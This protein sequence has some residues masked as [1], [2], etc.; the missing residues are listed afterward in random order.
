MKAIAGIL[1]L[2]VI[3]HAQHG[4]TS[5]S[6]FEIPVKTTAVRPTPMRKPS[7]PAMTKLALP[8]KE[9]VVGVINDGNVVAFPLA[10]LEKSNEAKQDGVTLKFDPVSRLATAT[11]K[12][13]KELPTE[14]LFGFAWQ[15]FNP[16]S[17][18][19]QP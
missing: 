19:W 3:G 1:S 8:E 10:R 5:R 13:G 6:F 7:T 11:V 2:L 14:T 15:A 16:Q 17:T 4:F 12:H 18:L 9:W